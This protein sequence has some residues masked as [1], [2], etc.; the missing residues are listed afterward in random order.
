[1]K[2][3][4]SSLPLRLPHLLAAL[5]LFGAAEPLVSPAEAATVYQMRLLRLHN[6]ERAKRKRPPL[7]LNAHL[8]RAALKYAR[9]MSRAGNNFLSHTGPDGSTMDQRI[10]RECATCFQTM[11]EN[12]ALGYRTEAEVNRGW[13]RSPGHRRN[14]LNPRF[15]FVGFGKAGTGPH[16]VT[17]FGG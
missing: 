9:V 14:I 13:M 6:K 1:M 8:N 5:I 11:G 16:W 2:S 12:I 17:N 3:G 10:R 15:K 7:K 4:L